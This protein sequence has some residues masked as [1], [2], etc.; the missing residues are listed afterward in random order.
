MGC[1]WFDEWIAQQS[2][3]GTVRTERAQ[4]VVKFMQLFKNTKF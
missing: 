4:R 1:N 3:G 2:K